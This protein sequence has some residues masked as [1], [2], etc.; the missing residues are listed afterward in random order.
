ML[1]H[2]CG[3]VVEIEQCSRELERAHPRGMRQS[4]LGFVSSVN[5]IFLTTLSFLVAAQHHCRN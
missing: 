4:P 1:F 3:I 5:G 2:F